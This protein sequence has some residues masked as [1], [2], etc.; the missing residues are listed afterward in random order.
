MSD[1]HL[2]KRKTLFEFPHKAPYLVLA[3]DIGDPSQEIYK[4]FLYKQAERFD[5][6]FVLS[7][8]HEYYSRTL[9]ETD[10]LIQNIC[11]GRDNLIYLNQTCYDL[12]DDHVILGTTLWS[13]MT[14]DERSDIDCFLADMRFIRNWSFEWN[15][16]QH[17]KE[18]RWLETAIK[19]VEKR[20]KL[21]IVVTHHSPS[22]KDTVA[23]KHRGNTLSSAFCTDLDHM[24][25]LPVV[26]H[27]FGHSH[28]SCNQY[29]PNGCRLVSNQA[30]YPGEET[31]F[32][33][34]FCVEIDLSQN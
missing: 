11:D 5:K 2:E 17:A 25:K 1:L 10:S 31:G 18:R 9:A 8:N 20:E 23:P 34:E 12:D 27:I 15:N 19:T 32:D 4:S 6:V 7:G 16:V 26:C 13:E 29:R 24:L 33:T 3:G 22:F 21:A 14:D 28:F 30:G